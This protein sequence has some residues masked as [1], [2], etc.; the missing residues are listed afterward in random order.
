MISKSIY[1]P[2]SSGMTTGGLDGYLGP[3][4]KDFSNLPEHIEEVD[5]DTDAKVVDCSGADANEAV[6]EIAKAESE[7]AKHRS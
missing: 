1:A 6:C 3:E 5:A 4:A 2:G 7:K